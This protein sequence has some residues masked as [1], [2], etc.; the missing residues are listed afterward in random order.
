M[1]SIQTANVV[2]IILGLVLIGSGPYI[3]F[4]TL[5]G[6][7]QRR[8]ED[9]SASLHLFSN[10]LNVIIGVLF[11]VAGILFVVNNLRGNPLG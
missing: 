8:R 2:L 3:I 7:L 4:R 1:H 9:P 10:L 5:D 6:V 11:L